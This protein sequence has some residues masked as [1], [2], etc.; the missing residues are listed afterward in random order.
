MGI[1]NSILVLLIVLIL[2]VLIKNAIIDKKTQ[3][4]EKFGNSEKEKDE[5]TNNKVNNKLNNTLNNSFKKEENIESFV[6]PV[7][8][9]KKDC[10]KKPEIND[11]DNDELLKFVYDDDNSDLSHFF[12]GM[13]VTKDVTEDIS[14]KLSCPLLKTDDNSLPLSTTCDPQLQKLRMEDMNKKIKQDCNLS[15]PI[16]NMLLK[17]YEDEN[18]MNG[19][20]LF[21]DLSAYDDEALNF[22]NYECLKNT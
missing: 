21:G 20:E 14:K 8:D 1:K 18:A 5:S 12:K 2:H 16:S 17:E 22:S 4:K 7:V 15:Q 9:E 10:V 6:A 13:D 3:S 19:G 11:D